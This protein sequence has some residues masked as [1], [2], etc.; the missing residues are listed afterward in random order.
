MTATKVYPSTGYDSQGSSNSRGS[1]SRH[2]VIS[3]LSSEKVA[4][5]CIV[6]LL[7]VYSV[8]VIPF[9]LG[10]DVE[11][12][13][14][15]VVFDF[16]VD[17][18]FGLDMGATFFT[19][20]EDDGSLNFNLKDI[21][22]NYLTTWFIPDFVSTV[23]FDSIVPLIVKGV[24]PGTLRSIKLVRALRLFR[25]LKLFR[26]ARLNR[27]VREAKV[28]EMVHPI[29]FELV[30]LFCKIF[31]IAHLLSCMFFYL[32]DCRSDPSNSDSTQDKWKACGH[33]GILH[34]EYL[35]AMYWTIAT[36]L[37]VGY[38]D[39]YL[40][41]NS[42]RLFSVAVMFIGSIM[43]GLIVATVTESVKNWDPREASRKVKMDEIREYMNERKLPKPLKAKVWQHYEYY[44]DKLA[45]F[46]EEALLNSLPSALQ[47]MVIERSR[48][49]LSG[50]KLF[51]SQDY[52]ILSEILPHVCPTF[53]DVDE[54]IVSEGDFLVDCFFVSQGRVHATVTNSLTAGR[55][56]L[57][58]VYTDGSDFGLSQALR[59]KTL[60]WSTHRS[61]SFTDL[62][63][64]SY[65]HIQQI[66]ERNQQL[67]LLFENRASEEEQSQVLVRQ[68]LSKPKD[69]GFVLMSDYVIRDGVVTC[70][71]EVSDMYY[72]H[73]D[74][75]SSVKLYKTIR[76]VAH[77]ADGL[78]VLQDGLE[79]TQQMLDR[80]IINP[81]SNS[82]R[83]FDVIVV[84]LVLFS[85]ITIPFRLG[86]GLRTDTL[87]STVDGVTEFVFFI[88]LLLAFFTAYEQSDY[89][90]NTVHKTIARRYLKS[91]FLIDFLSTIPLYRLSDN[92][93]SSSVFQIFK[94]LKMVKLFRML[95]VLRLAKVAKLIRIASYN[96]SRFNGNF[97]ALEDVFMRILRLI[98]FLGFVTHLTACLWAWTSLHSD[99]PTWYSDI[100][101]TNDQEWKKYVAAVYWTYATMATVG[102]G[103]IIAMNDSERL[104]SVFVMVMG[105]TVLA[106]IVGSV[107][108]YAF[109][110]NGGK[111]LQDQKL[112]ISR[113]YLRDQGVKKNVRQSLMK[114]VCHMIERRTSLDE[115]RIWLQVPH[116][117]RH[118]LILF[119]MRESI[120]TFPV[121]LKI[122]ETVLAVLLS[123]MD[124]CFCPATMYVYR[125][126]MGSAGV[127]F[128]LSGI[129]EVVDEIGQCM[130]DGIVVA[131]IQEGKFF[132]Y[133]GLLSLTTRSYGYRSKTDLSMLWVSDEKLLLMKKELPLV[134]NT[135]VDVIKSSTASLN[136]YSRRGDDTYSR[137]KYVDQLGKMR[138]GLTSSE[139]LQC[140]GSRS[141]SSILVPQQSDGNGE[142]GNT[143]YCSSEVVDSVENGNL[144][145]IPTL[146]SQ[147]VDSGVPGED[148]YQLP[149]DEF[150]MQTVD[151]VPP[152]LFSKASIVND[153]SDSTV[154]LSTDQVAQSKERKTL[155][156]DMRMRSFD[157]D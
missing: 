63:W 87:W 35:V 55:E 56:V 4:W 45:R 115:L 54:T 141:D 99:G 137:G 94:T 10:F 132:G 105:S 48:G 139:W 153:C 53:S 140:S 104:Y 30:G 100:G 32:S 31:L 133:D 73:I 18:A 147:V 75:D 121:L 80:W 108:T 107:S 123:L 14:A 51:R 36:M 109:N 112:S 151:S 127:Y 118:K 62:L 130:E 52:G 59:C 155:R 43:F 69:A 16:I 91:W 72:K 5:D 77:G 136:S 96:N 131:E 6:G 120:Q 71:S 3:P 145:L 40:S 114:H 103:D 58:G 42:G 134:F 1:E 29:V 19:A 150:T 148:V 38:G 142:A 7:I 13:S 113:E 39:V 86:F 74:K 138:Q 22:K 60:W 152:S 12:G 25:L 84:L 106:Y 23:P 67:K 49:G 95:K 82:K 110:K 116:N 98:A 57:V 11:K 135:F 126:E 90:L 65:S 111:S 15:V 129:A 68:Y 83:F 33:R 2:I 70:H 20:I 122:N 64:V 92:G 117:I 66:A 146:S 93:N 46:P 101:L 79:N 61:V 27:K 154:E 119:S 50:I 78:D 28:H 8:T 157:G 88:D 26:V 34:S 41:N 144:Q 9:R 85:S 149:S 76:V 24:A 47:M 102:Y 97:A 89:A 17:I 81:R 44:Y 125:K 124:P 156:N 128:I 21:A 37:S 143:V